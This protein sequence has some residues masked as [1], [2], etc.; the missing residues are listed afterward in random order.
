MKRIPIDQQKYKCILRVVMKDEGDGERG[1]VAFKKGNIYQ[2]IKIGLNKDF[3]D[4]CLIDAQKDQHWMDRRFLK[5]HFI[6]V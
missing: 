4:I 2:R 6:Q 1:D 3:P 5:K